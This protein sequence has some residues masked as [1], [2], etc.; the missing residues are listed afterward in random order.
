[1][2]EY[3]WTTKEFDDFHQTIVN[4]FGEIDKNTLLEL[5]EKTKKKLHGKI[6]PKPVDKKILDSINVEFKRITTGGSMMGPG[7]FLYE[8]SGQSNVLS[9]FSKNSSY[10]EMGHFIWLLNELNDDKKDKLIRIK[11]L[12][13][14]I[15][16]AKRNRGICDSLFIEFSKYYF[17]ELFMYQ[18]LILEYII[19]SS[20]RKLMLE[21]VENWVIET[22]HNAIRGRLIKFLNSFKDERVISTLI[23][24]V[25]AENENSGEALSSLKKFRNEEIYKVA[26]SMVFSTVRN[27]PIYA[28]EVLLDYKEKSSESIT[29]IEQAILNIDIYSISKVL[30]YMWSLDPN[31][32]IISIENNIESYLLP[33]KLNYFVQS[34]I[35]FDVNIISDNNKILYKNVAKRI[36][37]LSKINERYKKTITTNL[38]SM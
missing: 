36:L 25:Y 7:R 29:I 10:F 21:V 19:T 27:I 28:I 8:Q 1:M 32:T 26:S 9:I 6:D 14:A 37:E 18:D 24:L 23:N 12:L 2:A 15:Q 30:G 11:Y 34:F 22:Q 35:T 16:F 17:Q 33:E 38:E 3:K 13:L 31:F 5:I 20:N 4:K